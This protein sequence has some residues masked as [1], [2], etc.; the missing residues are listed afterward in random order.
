MIRIPL[1]ANKIMTVMT[2][3]IKMSWAQAQ[4]QN[5]MGARVKSSVVHTTTDV[6]TLKKCA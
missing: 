5:A 6:T 2:V 4:A 1:L 3:K